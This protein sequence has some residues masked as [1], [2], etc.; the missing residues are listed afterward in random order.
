[1]LQL[2]QPIESTQNIKLS[3]CTKYGDNKWIT[4]RIIQFTA[5]SSL[6]S[7]NSAAA[8]MLQLQQQH[9]IESIQ[10]VKLL[11]YTKYGNNI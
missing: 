3:L 4:S 2:Q 9:L 8:A 10:N 6:I 1:M 7:G 5:F 11:L